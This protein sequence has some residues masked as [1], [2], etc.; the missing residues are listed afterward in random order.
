MTL[1]IRDY[2]NGRVNFHALV[3]GLRKDLD[4]ANLKDQGLV[5]EWYDYFAPLEEA[6]TEAWYGMQDLDFEK[7]YPFLQKMKS[8]LLEHDHNLNAAAF[9]PSHHRK[10]VH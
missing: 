6:D 2:Y 9:H 4:L 3:C 1:L 5:R 8:F 7:I 10:L